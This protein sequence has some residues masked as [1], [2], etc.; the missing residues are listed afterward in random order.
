MSLKRKREHG[1]EET[2]SANSNALARPTQEIVKYFEEIREHFD[3]IDDKEEQA[4]L[5]NNALD[6]ARGQECAVAGDPACSRVLEAL[7]PAAEPQQVASF[8]QAVLRGDAGL[9][10]LASR[11]GACSARLLFE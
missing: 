10:V 4:L 6:E 9:L 1:P 11:C 7:I 5:V 2:Y 8:F 3:T